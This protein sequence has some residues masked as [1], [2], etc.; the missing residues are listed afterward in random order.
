MTLMVDTTLTYMFMFGNIIS[1]YV[2]NSI[3]I[4]CKINNVKAL[5][6]LYPVNLI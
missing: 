5:K 6:S 1:A 3:I 4:V 2:K